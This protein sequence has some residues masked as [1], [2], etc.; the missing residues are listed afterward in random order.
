[1]SDS[2]KD[3]LHAPNPND[4]STYIYVVSKK[5]E[6]IRLVYYIFKLEFLGIV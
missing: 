3:S 4:N 1:M 2:K 6:G 5:E